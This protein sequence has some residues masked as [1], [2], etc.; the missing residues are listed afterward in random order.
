MVGLMDVSTVASMDLPT[1]GYRVASWALTKAARMVGLM[2][3][4]MA[5]ST[6]SMT[7]G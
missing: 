4:P 6:V 2:D 3:I 5:A 7:V 1:V